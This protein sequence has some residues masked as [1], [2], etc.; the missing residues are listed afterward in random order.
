M[1]TDKYAIARRLGDLLELCKN[2]VVKLAIEF[3]NCINMNSACVKYPTCFQNLVKLELKFD[4]APFY[5]GMAFWG[6]NSHISY[7]QNVP[8]LEHFKLS[9]VVDDVILVGIH[10]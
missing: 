10:M 9:I 3:R 2:D 7:S 1:H 4:Q 8:S 5:Y 6:N